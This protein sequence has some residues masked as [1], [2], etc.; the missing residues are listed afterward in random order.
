MKLWSP[1]LWAP[2]VIACSL[3]WPRAAWAQMDLTMSVS[4]HEVAVGEALQVRLDAMSNDDQSPSAPELVVPSSFEVR[5][6]S[7]GTRQQVSI[8]GLSMVTQTG[9]SATWL[10]TPTRPGV[11]SIGPGSVQAGAHRQQAQP[12]QVRVLPEGQRPRA[13]GRARRGRPDPFDSLD[14][15]GSGG[16]FDDLFDRLRGGSSRFD[17]LPAAP[18]DLIPERALDSLAFLDAH[19]DTRRAVVGQQVTLAIYA[20]GAQGLFQE[21]P[22]AREPS[23]P[24]FLA[25]RL[26]EDGSRQPVYQYTLDGQRWLAVKVREIALF[27]LRSGQLEIGPLEFG[28]LG[29]RY[30]A[31]SGEGLRRS[32]RALRVDVSEPPAAGR[33]PGYA[34]DV[35]AFELSVMVEPRSIAVGGSIAVTARVHGVGRLPGAL[36]APEQTGVE[37]L[38]PTLRDELAVTG[39]SIGGSRTF[40]YLVRMTR[41]GSI[42]LG[43]LRLPHYEP[44]TQRYRLAEAPLGRVTVEPAIADPGTPTADANVAAAAGPRL[45]ELVKFRPEL[46]SADPPRYLADRALFWWLI[47]LGPVLVSVS[48][49]VF[50]LGRRA[51][52]R[53]RQ[54]DESQATHAT[55]AVGEA[56]QALAAAE[57]RRVASSAERAIYTAIEWATGLRVRAVLRSDLERT[58]QG[59][60]LSSEL[61]ARAALLLDQCG[62]LRLGEADGAGAAALIREV[63]A[64]V[65]QLVRRPAARPVATSAGEA[66][67]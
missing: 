30:G 4:A 45:S 32:S 13:R 25:Q 20:H 14:P 59:A 19:L 46:G 22:G 5:G 40:S 55:R 28:F 65:K 43:S 16:S 23:H 47:A 11:Y 18:L 63:E 17:Q 54:R 24:D 12:V 3:V 35:G 41:P 67:L 8:S 48:A 36:L 15:F 10:L 2:L 53:L 51:R 60:G 39:S 42:D 34:G 52:R 66:R 56:R 38:E 37:W 7:V 21:A 6:P 50:A 9:I 33:P 1:A 49:G 31:R 61:S 64:L 44:R 29:R 26:V 62:Q 27:P 58:L 57:L